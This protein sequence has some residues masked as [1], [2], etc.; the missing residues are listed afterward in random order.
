MCPD[1]S[2]VWMILTFCSKKSPT[3]KVGDELC[4]PILDLTH[5]KIHTVCHKIKQKHVVKYCIKW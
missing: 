3:S 5:A 1:G 2:S 4:L